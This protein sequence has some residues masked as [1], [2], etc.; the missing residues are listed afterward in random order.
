MPIELAVPQSSGVI[1]AYH[2]ATGG[3]YALG[4]ASLTVEVNSY[5][6]AAHSSDAPLMSQTI[7][8]SFVLGTLAP[9]PPAGSTVEH[10]VQEIV[11]Q[12]LVA[13]VGGVLFGGVQV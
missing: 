3:G 11:E 4:G 10:V 7:D 13:Q 2:V 1:A 8:I 5:L 6:D 9:A 12:A